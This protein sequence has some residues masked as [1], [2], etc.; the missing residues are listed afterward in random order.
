MCFDY[1]CLSTE[2]LLHPTIMGK[3]DKN[4][5]VSILGGGRNI[6]LVHES[7]LYGGKKNEKG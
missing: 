1:F 3:A 7:Q 2:E 5:M 6:H 4:G